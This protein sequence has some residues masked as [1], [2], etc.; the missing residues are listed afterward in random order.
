[1]AV[2]INTSNLPLRWRIIHYIITGLLGTVL[3]LII[4]LC[5]LPIWIKQ[6]RYNWADKAVDHAE[7]LRYRL[8]GN[9]Y[10]KY[11]L[12]EKIKQ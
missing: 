4:L 5:G 8:L 10:E 11:N 12:F 9:I 6:D 3:S 1:M 7:S 2:H